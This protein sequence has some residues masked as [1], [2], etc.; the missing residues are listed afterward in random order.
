MPS[1]K[2]V[3]CPTFKISCKLIINTAQLV[4]RVAE[5]SI[6]SYLDW[7]QIEIPASNLMPKFT[8]FCMANLVLLH[9]C[10][11][12]YYPK[13]ISDST[14]VLDAASK[15]ASIGCNNVIN[16]HIEPKMDAGIHAPKLIASFRCTQIVAS[17]VCII[18]GIQSVS[19]SYNYCEKAKIDAGI[20]AAK[21]NASFDFK[22][23]A[24]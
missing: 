22:Q 17:I 12:V 7:N 21:L 5:K 20:Y 8:Q 23:T 9:F 18:L 24:T 15:C 14:K 13:F 4:G 10:L 6:M 11:L 1:L 16:C 19:S 3:P 2:L